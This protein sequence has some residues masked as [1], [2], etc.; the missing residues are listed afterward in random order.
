MGQLVDIIKE[1][2]QQGRARFFSYKWNYLAVVTV[3]SFLLHYVFWWAGRSVLKTKLDSLTWQNHAKHLSYTI[4]LTS[5]CFLS[6]AILLAFVQNV[7]FA[8]ANSTIGPL[9]QAFIKMLFDVM[10]FFFNFSFVFL[11]FVVSYTKLYLQYEKAREYFVSSPVGTNITD[12]LRLE[13]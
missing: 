5:D 8:E 12:P 7:S 3:A 10:K 11:A 2:Y 9:L 1:V 6:V 13:R 4:V